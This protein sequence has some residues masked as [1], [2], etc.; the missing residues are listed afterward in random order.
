MVE[1]LG[2][3]QKYQMGAFLDISQIKGGI[4]KNGKQRWVCFDT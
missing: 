4:P 2:L 3:G 1:S